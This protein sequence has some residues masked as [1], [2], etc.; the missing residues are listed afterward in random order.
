MTTEDSKPW[1]MRAFLSAGWFQRQPLQWCLLWWV[2]WFS[3]SSKIFGGG[4]RFLF[5]GCR[6]S[7]KAFSAAF[8]W[9]GRKEVW[10]LPVYN[11]VRDVRKL[12]VAKNKLRINSGYG[13]CNHRFRNVAAI[14][15]RKFGKAGHTIVQV[16]GRNSTAAS[17]LGVWVWYH[18]HQLQRADCKECRCVHHCSIRQCYWWCNWWPAPERKGGG[19]YSR[20]CANGHIERCNRT[21]WCVLPAAK[22]A[23]GYDNIAGHSCLFWTAAMKNKEGAGKSWRI[24]LQ[25]R[26]WQKPVMMSGWRWL[27]AVVVNNFT[28]HLY[29]LVKNTAVKRAE[30]L[31]NCPADWRNHWPAEN[32]EPSVNKQGRR[33]G[34]TGRPFKNIL[35]CWI[36]HPQ[37]KKY[38]FA[39]DGEYTAGV[40]NFF[41]PRR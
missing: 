19:A 14:L 35:P 2:A 28:N 38:L 9:D 13:Y 4:F 24:L 8:F 18:L 12:H 33:C 17:E 31:N 16:V 20:F 10:I 15:G 41:T 37:L 11:A 39:A 32:N 5:A 23:E 29:K 7:V 36:K 34:M 6:K 21:L 25:K 30:L 40:V 26:K 27:A 22:P 3:P 1:M